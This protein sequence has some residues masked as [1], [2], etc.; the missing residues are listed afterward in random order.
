VYKFT[1]VDDAMEFQTNMDDFVVDQHALSYNFNTR[2]LADRDPG[3]S[4]DSS[5][6]PAAPVHDALTS[7]DLVT[8]TSEFPNVCK[9]RGR[10]TVTVAGRYD[11]MSAN[12]SIW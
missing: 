12:N 2:Q 11:G 4:S 5:S 6:H 7:P 8:K 9:N 3:C 1:V 10:E